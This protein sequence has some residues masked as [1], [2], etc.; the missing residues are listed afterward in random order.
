VQ[1]YINFGSID[2]SALVIRAGSGH[3]G[4]ITCD[5]A[6]R[7]IIREQVQAWWDKGQKSCTHEDRADSKP[8]VVPSP[9]PAEFMTMEWPLDALRQDLAGLKFTAQIRRLTDPKRK[10][11][12]YE[13][14]EPRIVG[15]VAKNLRISDVRLYVNDQWQ[16]QANAFERIDALVSPNNATA[17]FVYP[18]L[19]PE[20]V[21]LLQ[22]KGE[23]DTIGLGFR[24][25]QQAERPACKDEA[26][27]NALVM[28]TVVA[29]NC[30][31][32]H[33]AGMDDTAMARRAQDK[34]LMSTVAR[35]LCRSFKERGWQRDD[36]LPALIQYPLF[37]KFGHPR[38]LGSRDEVVPDWI[39]WLK[40]EY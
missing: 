14:R 21:I 36:I 11:G 39:D 6:Q 10:T 20:S 16:D 30:Q 29:R 38:V 13:L 18:V 2:E 1:N 15:S 26:A 33:T 23:G 27:F 7:Q 37:G 31:Y 35:E 19:S 25:I 5:L 8:I 22:R 9:L 24:V 4:C 17:P 40:R 28:P 12:S 34:F 32:C 3:Q